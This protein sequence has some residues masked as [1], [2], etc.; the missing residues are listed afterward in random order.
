VYPAEFEGLERSPN[1]VYLGTTPNQIVLPGVDWLCR[2]KACRRVFFV[3]TNEVFDHAITTIVQ[4]HLTAHWPDAEAVGVEYLTS[5]EDLPALLP[6]LRAARPDL[7]VNLIS[8]DQNIEFFRALKDP[9][10]GVQAIPVLAVDCTEQEF[11]SLTPRQLADVYLVGSY[12]QALDGP[13]NRAFLERWH[14]RY[15]RH[16][17]TFDV[18][19]AAYAG[20][21][22]W[23]KAVRE[24]RTDDPAAIRAALV[25]QEY[26]A[27]E[28]A[29]R[30]DPATGHAWRAA[31]LARFDQSGTL[32]VVW[33]SADLVRPVPYPPT[34]PE[35][36]WHGYLADLHRTWGGHW[37]K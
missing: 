11:R 27:P 18:M 9:R 36:A 3:G 35:I 23:V 19:Q 32:H 16:R 29:I 14:A 37:A 26:A 1:V 30:L 8:G 15:G 31:R 25:R 17:V 7:I 10:H 12:F 13:A 33:S 24:A 4:D 28:G 22:L 5:N 21:H 2:E 20:V 34:R 6:K